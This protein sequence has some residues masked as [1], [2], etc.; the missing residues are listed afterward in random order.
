[1]DSIQTYQERPSWPSIRCRPIVLVA[2]AA[3]LSSVRVLASPDLH[4]TRFAV[5]PVSADALTEVTILVTLANVGTTP[6][7]A[8]MAELRLTPAGAALSTGA[9]A[10]LRLSLPSL[11]VGGTFT[12][13]SKVIIPA[14][15]APGAK[16]LW[17]LIDGFD[18]PRQGSRSRPIVRVSTPFTILGPTLP[19]PHA[20]VVL[21]AITVIGKLED[22]ADDRRIKSPTPVIEM[23][24]ERVQ[25][26]G[27][28]PAGQAM[29]GFPML[30]VSGPPG[31]ATDVRFR[32]LRMGYTSVLI[33]GEPIPG[34]GRE[35]QFRV[36]RLPTTLIDRINVIP[37][38]SS[39]LPQEGIGGTLDIRLSDIPDQAHTGALLRGGQVRGINVGGGAFATGDT[40]GNWGWLLAGSADRL[41]RWSPQEQQTINPVGTRTAI[42]RRID[43]SRVDEYNITPRLRWSHDGVI[44]RLD[45][46]LLDKKESNT[47]DADNY[48]GVGIFQNH[49][50][51]AIDREHRVWRAKGSVTL[52]I[53]TQSDLTVGGLLQGSRED[54]DT[55]TE[56]HNAAGVL[57]TRVLENLIAQEWRKK[58]FVRIDVTGISGH[59][60]AAGIEAGAWG[61]LDTAETMNLLT[62][63]STIPNPGGSRN[64]L[65]EH[66]G[67]VFALD[68]MDLTGRQVLT[69]GFRA[70]WRD[71]TVHSDS[72]QDTSASRIVP[73]PSLHWLWRTTDNTSLRA[74]V[75]REMRWPSFN[76]LSS[77]IETS[78]LNSV[79]TPDITG[80][81]NLKPELATGLELGVEHRVKDSYFV[82]LNG[83]YRRIQDVVE[84]QTARERGRWIQR[85]VNS[86]D[87]NF[88]GGTLDG[89]IDLSAIGLHGCWLY[90]NYTRLWSRTRDT[91]TGKTR[92]LR[93]MP[94]GLAN[95]GFDYRTQLWGLMLGASYSY[96]SGYD[97]TEP[98]D[99]NSRNVHGVEESTG[100]LDAYVAK[101]LG[102]HWLARLTG[103]NLTATNKFK[104]TTIYNADGGLNQNQ[105]RLESSIRAV[106]FSLEADF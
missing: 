16:E 52:P 74:S 33:D 80:D 36:D 82:G 18:A 5:S 50:G 42:Q 101:Q 35:R 3:F 51:V 4:V 26:L 43:E 97:N 70:E 41:E 102:S 68:H 92:K 32:G 88:S 78:A 1:M 44:I 76:D 28:M 30:A 45:P 89:R 12:S 29:R 103:Q 2:V 58:G 87:A 81:P 105:T 48:N 98:Q 60:I 86:G 53:A 9:T 57:A 93:E 8:S 23:P 27:M 13:T 63:V 20:P 90:A 56:V 11:P 62:G 55:T 17:F 96:N 72:G 47:N 94:D 71:L 61:R 104:A 79:D 65:N 14:D 15:T 99:F 49:Q 10:L 46:F 91:N 7:N 37:I 59:Q 83:F 84:R 24:Q 40:V 19:N 77:V 25:R 6:A 106:T 34:G 31:Y 69:V 21:D 64:D 95:I 100:F 22:T 73:L 66:F 85:P 75:A 39:D 67:T 54:R 38:A